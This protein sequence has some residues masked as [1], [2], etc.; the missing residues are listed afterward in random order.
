MHEPVSKDSFHHHRLTA[1]SLCPGGH[2]VSEKLRGDSAFGI[3]CKR[4]GIFGSCIWGSSKHPCAT[5]HQCGIA[6]GGHSE[7]DGASISVLKG[8]PSMRGSVPVACG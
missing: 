2:F 5:Q 4:G 1:S 3:V 7:Y 8:N 6:F